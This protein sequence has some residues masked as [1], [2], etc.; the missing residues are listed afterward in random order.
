MHYPKI[1]L[2]R[3]HR[4]NNRE[5]QWLNGAIKIIIIAV[6]MK[7]E[8]RRHVYDD[9]NLGYLM[10]SLIETTGCCFIFSLLFMCCFFFGILLT[11][12]ARIG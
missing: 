8:T 6:I 7:K 10:F 1:S 9:L 11:D 12:D 2:M 5:K 3:Q 4:Q